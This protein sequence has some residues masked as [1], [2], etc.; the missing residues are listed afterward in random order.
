MTGSLFRE[1][2]WTKNLR[3]IFGADPLDGGEMTLEGRPYRADNCDKAISQGV[4]YMTEDR[5]SLGLYL[6]FD[7]SR[8]IAANRLGAFTNKAGFIQDTLL[9][10]D[11]EKTVEE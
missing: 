1:R 9:R 5:K 2:S 7:I 8:N 11:A 3:A 4:G 6:A 10:A